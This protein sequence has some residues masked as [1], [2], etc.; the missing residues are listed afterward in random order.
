VAKHQLKPQGNVGLQVLLSREQ[1]R[2]APGGI[3]IATLIRL[4]QRGVLRA[5]KLTPGSENSKTF[6][7]VENIQALA[8]GDADAPA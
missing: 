7:S 1:A 4:E 3:S 8:R 5:I 2:V 6:Y